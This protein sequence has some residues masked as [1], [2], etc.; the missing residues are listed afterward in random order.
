MD[1][2]LQWHCTASQIALH[3]CVCVCECYPCVSIWSALSRKTSSFT[4]MEVRKA[5]F[6][7][8][9]L[10]LSSV[11]HIF[12]HSV[13]CRGQG[14][15]TFF[16]IF[17][18]TQYSHQKPLPLDSLIFHFK[19]LHVC[20]F[21]LRDQFLCFTLG[22]EAVVS[23]ALTMQGRD[24]EGTLLDYIGFKCLIIVPWV[25]PGKGKSQCGA[26]EEFSW[27]EPACFTPGVFSCEF[28]LLS[29]SVWS[30]MLLNVS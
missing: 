5:L 18:R 10:T 30:Q 11:F 19:Y 12:L 6:C 17:L 20:F 2:S 8:V 27:K 21:N 29:L 13:S 26:L 1:F 9:T 25:T 16:A 14:Y 24:Q 7:W 23:M 15:C 22:S 4:N 28:I 3:W